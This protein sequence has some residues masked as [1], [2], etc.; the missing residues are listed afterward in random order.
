MRVVRVN[1]LKLSD[2][3]P[4]PRLLGAEV[5]MRG[6]LRGVVARPRAPRDALLARP[7]P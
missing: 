6:I 7:G 5:G 2:M 3:A 1:D 4:A